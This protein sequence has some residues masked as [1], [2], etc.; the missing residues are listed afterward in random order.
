M[1]L[2][3]EQALFDACLA[4]AAPHREDLLVACGDEALA[5][6]VRRLLAI[7]D[8]GAA[9]L[10][11]SLQTLSPLAMPRSIGPY[12]V[13]ERLGEGAMGEVFLGEQLEPVRRRVAIKVIKF[14]LSTRDVIARF[15][16][17]RQALVL[18]T[19]CSIARILD[20]GTTADGR[21]YFAMEYVDGAPITRYCEERGLGLPERLALFAQVCAGVQ[22]AHL[23]GIIHRD[24]KPNNILVTEADG[25]PAPRIIDFGIAKATTSQGID[26]LAQTRFGHLLGTPEYMSPEQA[27]L[28]PLEVDLRTDVYSLGVILYELL[29]GQRPYVVSREAISPDRLALEIGEGKVRRPSECVTGVRADLLRGDLDW[30]VLKAIEK[31]RTRRYSSVQE[32]ADDLDRHLDNRPV[33]AGPPSFSY[34]AGRFVRRHRLAVALTLS[35]FAAVLAFGSAMAWL[36]RENARE[37]DRAN[38]EAEIARRVTAFT[39]SLFGL[40]SPEASNDSEISARE[41]LDAGVGRLAGGELADEPPEVR[42]ALLE[43]A[44]DA[45]R[46]FGEF[47]KSSELIESAVAIRRARES[48]DPVAYGRALMFESLLR[49][50]EGKFREAANLARQAMT[51]FDAAD[52]AGDPAAREALTSARVELAEILRR[53]NQLDEAA[54]LA[55]AA[56][57]DLDERARG[58]E[59]HI[60]AL[61]MLGRVEQARGDLEAAEPLLRRAYDLQTKLAGELSDGTVNARNGLADLLVVRGKTEEAE[62][63]L[64]RNVD[65]TRK[66]YGESSP[67]LGIAWN[68]LA[69]A[70]SDIPEKYDEAE[71]AYLEAIR[72]LEASLEP[73]HPEIA[74]AHNNLGAL[75]VKTGEFAKAELE[76]ATA[77][78]LREASLGPEHPST[79]SS[80][81]G[82]ALAKN[83]LGQRAEAEAL[84]RDVKT[85]FG[86]SL[87]PAHWRTANAQYQLAVVLQE[88]GKLEE[89]LAEA[90]PAQAILLSNLGPEHPR[91]VAATKTLGELESATRG[92]LRTAR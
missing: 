33:L 61:F 70:T 91:T 12:R 87:G 90:R 49:R 18:L 83:R 25:K 38:E 60:S 85:S 52:I 81:M 7:H 78:R 39:A 21:P 32:L 17:E 11:A 53:D 23:R 74:N 3:A 22:H 9:E 89:A 20:A 43:A 16:L 34:R 88:R 67:S 75:Y 1:N 10:E 15:E 45:Y 48:D 5:A 64:R 4:A 14:G 55:R 46:A 50:D 86:K 68:N 71:K 59:S 44:G 54:K 42:A 79:I 57:A 6:R 92:E 69:N 82:I 66:I 62:S 84:L 28:A 58:T 37:R 41:L 77:L 26:T 73:G 65:A 19:H 63:L 40:A 80:R 13:L 56:L 27:R 47:G 76:H 8:G 29:T 31:D 72:I 30:I 24:L 35:L 51:R 2:E 36:A